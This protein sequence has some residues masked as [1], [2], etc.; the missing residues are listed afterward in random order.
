MKQEISKPLMFGIIAALVVAATIG[1]YFFVN[2]TTSDTNSTVDGQRKRAEAAKNDPMAGYGGSK[3][4]PGG[5]GGGGYGGGYGGRPMGMGGGS[6][7]MGG[8]GSQGR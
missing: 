7:S 4:R 6:G 3:G 1:G 5:Q 8:S 2:R